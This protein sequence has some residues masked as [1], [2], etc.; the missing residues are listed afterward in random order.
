MEQV[1]QKVIKSFITNRAAT[2]ISNAG[3]A[4]YDQI[5]QL[6][7]GITRLLFSRSDA[8]ANGLLFIGNTTGRLYAIVGRCSAMSIFY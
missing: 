1:T 2:D 4:E 3:N 7:K 8:G 6:E 5:M